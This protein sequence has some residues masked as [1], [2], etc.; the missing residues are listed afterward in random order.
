MN[1]KANNESELNFEYND[2]QR[3]DDFTCVIQVVYLDINQRCSHN[4]RPDGMI[5]TYCREP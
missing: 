5:P 2:Q 1:L 4:K 3:A